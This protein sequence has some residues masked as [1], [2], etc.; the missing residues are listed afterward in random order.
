MPPLEANTVTAVQSY[1]MSFVEPDG[2]LPWSHEPVLVHHLMLYLRS[3]VI[4]SSHLRV[5]IQVSS[6]HQIF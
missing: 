5:V 6:S 4:L 1:F 3:I 2:S